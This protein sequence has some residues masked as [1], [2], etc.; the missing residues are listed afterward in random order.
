MSNLGKA[1]WNDPERVKRLAASYSQRYGETFWQ[2][3]LKLTGAERRDTVLDLG[4]GPGL[5][6]VDAVLRYKARRVIGLDASDAM[7]EQARDFLR[8]RLHS[9][10]IVLHVVD[11]DSSETGLEAGTI[12]LAFSGF[13]L[14]EIQNPEGLL[15]QVY[16]SLKSKGVYAVY[17]FVSGNVA[18]FVNHMKGAGM[19]ETEAKNRYPHMC[20][21]SQSQFENMLYRAGFSRVKSSLIDVRA[22]FVGL[23][24]DK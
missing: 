8:G 24:G 6:L 9:K 16:E 5:F 17:E 15:T 4:C 22:V 23:K 7:L 18:E 21:Y 13:L 1:D 19:S 10:M 2:A 14:H 3:L 20:K 12:D 11:F